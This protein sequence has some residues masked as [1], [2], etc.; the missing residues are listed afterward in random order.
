MNK[1]INKTDVGSAIQDLK[2][3]VNKGLNVKHAKYILENIFN[4]YE[5]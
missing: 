3:V 2:N 5:F 4:V 1:Q